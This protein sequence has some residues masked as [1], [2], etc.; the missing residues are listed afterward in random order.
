VV[1]ASL[2]TIMAAV[3]SPSDRPSRRSSKRGPLETNQVREPCRATRHQPHV[4]GNQATPDGDGSVVAAR[5]EGTTLTH[6][7]RPSPPVLETRPTR[8][9]PSACQGRDVPHVTNVANSNARGLATRV[10]AVVRQQCGQRARYRAHA[11]WHRCCGSR[12]GVG[13][14]TSRRERALGHV[15]RG[16]KALG[17][18]AHGWARRGADRVVLCA[19]RGVGGDSPGS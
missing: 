11:A 4:A 17:S 12:D 9:E 8:E 5:S 18:A 10:V 1:A 14:L 7:D 16:D 15:R 2:K 6:R 13:V 3:A 19:C